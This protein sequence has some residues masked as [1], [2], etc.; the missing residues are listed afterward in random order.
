MKRVTDCVLIGKYRKNSSFHVSFHGPQSAPVFF[1]FLE[2]GGEID[3][4]RRALVYQA[5]LLRIHTFY[6][7]VPND[8]E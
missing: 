4:N 6:T 7:Y 5:I 3:G 8:A 2:G 1:A